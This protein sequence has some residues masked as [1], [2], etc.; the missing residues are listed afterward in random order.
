[1]GPPGS[2]KPE[3]AVVGGGD[4]PNFG[5]DNQVAVRVFALP[6]GDDVV[7]VKDAAVRRRDDLKMAGGSRRVA[8]HADDGEGL[9][10]LNRLAALDFIEEKAKLDRAG[11]IGVVIVLGDNPH[12]SAGI[13]PL[14]GGP[15]GFKLTRNLS[16]VG[17]RR[18]QGKKNSTIWCH[19]Q[20][21]ECEEKLVLISRFRFFIVGPR[22]LICT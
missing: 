7:A 14:P 9:G 13:V 12:H 17:D 20:R 3:G 11:D 10:D 19:F 18:L 6:L 8:G 22:A 2:L 15:R 5:R 16:L 4:A 1:M 21:I